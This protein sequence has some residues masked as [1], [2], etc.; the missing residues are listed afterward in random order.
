[1]SFVMCLHVAFFRKFFVAA[2]KGAG[3]GL[4]TGV[5]VV[6]NF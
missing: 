4:L 6:V 2:G 1:M 3:V 5:S